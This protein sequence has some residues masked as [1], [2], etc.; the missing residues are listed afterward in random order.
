MSNNTLALTNIIKGLREKGT[1]SRPRLVLFFAHQTQNQSHIPDVIDALYAAI[2]KEKKEKEPD[3]PGKPVN[4]ELGLLEVSPPQL[5]FQLQ[6][7][8]RIFG[9][10]DADKSSSWEM[11]KGSFDDVAARYWIGDPPQETEIGLEI[12]PTTNQVTLVLNQANQDQNMYNYVLQIDKQSEVSGE[13]PS[14]GSRESFT[15]SQA[16]IYRVD[17]GDE[18]DPWSSNKDGVIRRI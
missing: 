1:E 7:T 4:S 5:L 9:L 2:P 14:D 13:N 18:F 15:V 12:D 16:S 3:M 6:P 17:G 10:K 11:K 8:P